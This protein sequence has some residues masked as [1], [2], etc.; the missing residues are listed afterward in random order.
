MTKEHRI[1]LRTSNAKNGDTRGG[2]NMTKHRIS[3]LLGTGREAAI[4]GKELAAMAGI[5]RRGVTAMIER[6][7]REG[8]PI[9]A[10]VNGQREQGY[11]LAADR[12]ELD[13]YC[14]LLGRRIGNLTQTHSYLVAQVDKL[15]A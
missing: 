13:A 9:C 7:R 2:D 4:T 12:E 5:T 10:E 1:P 14:H 3:Q 8:I 6:E 11:Y 15:P